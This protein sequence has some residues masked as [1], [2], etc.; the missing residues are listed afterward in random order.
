M[1]EG[2]HLA[3][4]LI[5]FE[6]MYYYLRSNLSDRQDVT[7]VVAGLVQRLR[8]F[9]LDKYNEEAISL[10]AYAD[11]ERI[12]ENAQGA[13]Y[14]IGVETHN[15]LGTD[16]KNAADMKLCIDALTVLY[17][18][19]E[20]RSFIV[21]AGDRDYIPVIQHLRKHGRTVRVVGFP[22]SMSGDLLT[23]VGVENFLDASQFLPQP[24]V[25]SVSAFA[26]MPGQPAPN[27]LLP[28]VPRDPLS[29]QP[30]VGDQ[31][32]AVGIFYHY[33][34]EKPEVWMTPFLH[35]LRAE[36]PH[37]SEYE[38]KDLVAHMAESGLIRIE[39]R[40]GVPHEFSVILVNWNHPDVRKQP[41]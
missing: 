2:R 33:F 24:K 16:H 3:T 25:Q 13:L 40:P 29:L 20:I 26:S 17:T 19:Q 4:V 8:R 6:N 23:N 31:Q 37:L 30:L 10:D 22:S 14:L 38:R 39:K 9:L 1:A 35:K 15:V 7:D 36:L 32:T 41:A 21:V 27:N 5:D 18:R 12:D 34:R 28:T 11:F